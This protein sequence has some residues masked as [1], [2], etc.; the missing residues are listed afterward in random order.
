[1]DIERSRS[2]RKAATEAEGEEAENDEDLTDGSKAETPQPLEEETESEAE[3]E[4]LATPSD[5]DDNS[6]QGEEQEGRPKR[7]NLAKSA[8]AP[9]PP[10]RDLPFLRRNKNIAGT[11][12]ESEKQD[13]QVRGREEI[14]A[15]EATGG[16]T[17]DDEL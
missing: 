7:P 12:A 3:K 14:D 17:D 2:S 5:D 9:A 16:E 15:D 10:R 1:M 11:E 6:N 13:P 4:R 8:E